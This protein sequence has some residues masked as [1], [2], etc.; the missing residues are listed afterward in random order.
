MTCSCDSLYIVNE[1]H[2]NFDVISSC[3]RNIYIL[4]IRRT[5]KNRSKNRFV[6]EEYTPNKITQ[7]FIYVVLKQMNYKY[8]SALSL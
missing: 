1:R 7:S 5:S 3:E 4:T 8:H 2:R 6:N